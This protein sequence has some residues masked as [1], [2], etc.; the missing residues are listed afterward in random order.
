M[1][2]RMSQLNIY[3][4]TTVLF[5]LFGNLLGILDL[6]QGPNDMLS[7]WT[8][9]RKQNVK[10]TVGIEWDLSVTATMWM[11]WSEKLY[12]FFWKI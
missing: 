7:L 11:I 12:I 8:Y 4:L 6:Q 2:I 9:W 10:K 3:F 1:A 5:S